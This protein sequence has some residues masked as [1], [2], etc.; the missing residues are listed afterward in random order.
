MQAQSL[1]RKDPLEEGMATNSSILDWRIPRTEEPSEVQPTKLQSQTLLKQLSR[2]ACIPET[3][4]MLY[5]N[6]TSIKKKTV[7]F[8]KLN[9]F[10]LICKSLWLKLFNKYLMVKIQFILQHKNF[11]KR[12]HFILSN[13]ASEHTGN[14]HICVTVIRHFY[15]PQIP[16]PFLPPKIRSWDERN[17]QIEKIFF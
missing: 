5:V 12:C 6:Y 9:K 13:S 8:L 16:H 1:G 3:T 10:T 15:F 11:I 14:R 17:S 4:I 7:L 2:H